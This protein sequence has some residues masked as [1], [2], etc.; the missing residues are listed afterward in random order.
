MKLIFSDR[1]DEDISRIG[2]GHRAI[3]LIDFHDIPDSKRTK[4]GFSPKWTVGA[5]GVKWTLKRI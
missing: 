2:F 3:H 5:L 4:K 1:K